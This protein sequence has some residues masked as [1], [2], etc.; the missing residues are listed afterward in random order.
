MTSLP[1]SHLLSKAQCRDVSWRTTDA[2]LWA[3]SPDPIPPA[4]A[5]ASPPAADPRDLSPRRPGY[6][7]R[8]RSGA[9]NGMEWWQCWEWWRLGGVH[10][11]G[12]T[13]IAGWFIT[14]NPTKILK[15]MMT[16]GTPIWGNLHIWGGLGRNAMWSLS[17]STEALRIVSS[18][19]MRFQYH[20]VD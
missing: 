2:P 17:M 14:E 9:G 16:R 3:R 12:G 15:W 20:F 13:P 1:S 19:G 6:C 7:L 10:G 8:W 11:H 18:S 4:M 5:G